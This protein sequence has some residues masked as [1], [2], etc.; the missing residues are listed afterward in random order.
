M[1]EIYK[2][3]IQ[4]LCNKHNSNAEAGKLDEKGKLESFAAVKQM[5]N[6]IFNTFREELEAEGLKEPI[7]IQVI[8]KEQMILC[9]KEGK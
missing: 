8:N 5:N 4:L 6:K 3:I 1:I 9:L 7:E 2:S